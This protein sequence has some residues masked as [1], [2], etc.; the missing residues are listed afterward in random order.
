[1]SAD[2]P[3]MSSNRPYLVRALYQWISDNGLTPH[4]LV[5]ASVAGVQVPA[6]AVQD[7]RVVLNV[8]ARAVSQFD[9]AD[10]AVRFLAR[11]GGVSQS[12]QVP[13]PAVLAIYARENNQGMMFPPENAPP[14]TPPDAPA[15]EA[16][17][18]R[19]HLRIVK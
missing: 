2:A 14:A 17:P 6:S 7:G 13:M 12:V 4:L 3:A 8:A 10:D 19:S 18:R 5:D 9:V 11:F 1:M 15:P 16:P